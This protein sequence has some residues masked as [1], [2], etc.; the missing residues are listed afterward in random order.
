MDEAR[1]TSDATEEFVRL[2]TKNERRVYAFILTLIANWADADEILQETNARL[3]KEFSRYQPGSDFGAW[4][5]TVAKYQVLTFLKKQGRERLEFV[6][7][8]DQFIQSVATQEAAADEQLSARHL[9]LA[10]C[11]GKLSQVNRDLIQAYYRP[12]ATVKALA[13]RFG[14]R[15]TL[16][17]R[18]CRACAAPCTS[19]STNNSL[20]PIDREA[21]LMT[22][23]R[24]Q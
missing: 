11:L 15:P 7:F 1:P 6:G 3:W 9:A 20:D 23:G 2:L 17:I 4:A 21:T 13:A 14:A 19:A 12:G 5:C 10:R 22:K 18:R 24:I 16:S 8:S